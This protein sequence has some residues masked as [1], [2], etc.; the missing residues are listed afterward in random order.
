MLAAAL[1][2]H[3]LASTVRA[4]DA[5][6]SAPLA[7]HGEDTAKVLERARAHAASGD[8]AHARGLYEGLLAQD[9]ELRD[10]RLG[11][12]RTDG[13][14]RCYRRAEHAYRALLRANPA[15]AEARSGLID[16]LFWQDRRGEAT[17]VLE[18]GLVHSPRSAELW[19]R[20]SLLSLRN[21][22]RQQALTAAERALALAPQDPE[23][24]ALRERIYMSVLRAGVR[25]DAF[26]ADS[27]NLYKGMLGVWH[28][29]G[30]FEL[31]A[32]ALIQDRAGG[33]LTSP[34]VDGLYTL[35]AGYHTGPLA[36][37]GV[38]VGLGAPARSLPRY[39]ARAWLSSNFVAHWSAGLSY[40]LW[41]YASDKT[42][43][44]V[45]PELAFTP[46]DDWR[47]ELRGWG[48]WLVA[49]DAVSGGSHLG[50]ALAVGARVER[51]V[52]RGVRLAAAYTYGP[53]LDHVVL[54]PDFVRLTSHVL[55]LIGDVALDRRYGLQPIAGLEHRQIQQR[56]QWI[57]SAELGA[58]MR[59]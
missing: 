36:S 30:R 18:Q 7:V 42:A 50:T 43:H 9:P 32:D 13:W 48:T 1:G 16:V 49:H 47:F 45:A 2:G 52:V 29:L 54:S 20:S 34:I 14:A 46:D 19:Q 28:R 59:W 5:C 53:Q 39:L 24:R 40:A 22:D 12:A 6:A 44:I 3:A 33:A 58:Y 4:D 8:Y 15:D 37:L 38:S 31:S 41:R 55:A 51:Q 11:L 17:R 35:G 57:W 27:P 10:A 56:A 25:V 23:L 21:D 26:P